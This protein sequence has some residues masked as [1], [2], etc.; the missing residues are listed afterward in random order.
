MSPMEKG[1][2]VQQYAEHVSERYSVR[3]ERLK[4]KM[5]GGDICRE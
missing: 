5:G 2:K 3:G 1:I 4:D